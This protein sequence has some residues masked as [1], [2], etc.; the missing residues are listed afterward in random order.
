MDMAGSAAGD[1][2]CAA[3]TDGRRLDRLGSIV[4][5]FLN[6][7]FEWEKQAHVEAFRLFCNSGRSVNDTSCQVDGD[8]NPSGRKVRTYMHTGSGDGTVEPSW[9]RHRGTKASRRGQGRAWNDFVVLFY[10]TLCRLYSTSANAHYFLIYLLKDK[11]KQPIQSAHL[12]IC[13]FIIYQPSF[14][15][16][17][18]LDLEDDVDAIGTTL[19]FSAMFDFNDLPPTSSS[20]QRS[21]GGAGEEHPSV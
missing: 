21:V 10:S 8:A 15:M 5:L 11:I 6:I 2:R 3:T 1:C 16:F 17:P 14:I 4:S 12:L 7:F 9:I 20:R 19:G 18:L 13:S